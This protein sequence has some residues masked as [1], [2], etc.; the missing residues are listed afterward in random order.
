MIDAQ[1]FAKVVGKRNRAITA[2]REAAML[3]ADAMM[4]NG[5]SLAGSMRER[6]LVVYR[7]LFELG[8]HGTLPEWH[9]VE[10]GKPC[11]DGEG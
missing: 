1:R 2:A 8:N 6:T 11:G 4:M 5:G 3:I 10:T 7:L 9:M